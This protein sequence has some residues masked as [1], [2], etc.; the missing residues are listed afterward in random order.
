MKLTQKNYFSPKANLEYM[1]V[2]QFKS[3]EKC[4]ATALAEIHGT[5]EREK[6]TALL[7]GSYV[8]AY[9]EGQ[10][11][12]F[13]IENPQIFKRDAT[14]KA[15]YAQAD[16]I[17]QR[18]L[19]DKLFTEYMSGKKQ[20][21]M[22]GEI[23]GVPVKIKV[24]SL[25]TDKIVDLK[26][27]RDFEN[28]RDADKGI[29][30]WFE[31]WSYDLQGAVYQEIVRQNTGKTLPFY[32]AAATKEKVPDIDI[33]HLNQKA[34]DFAFARFKDNVEMYDAVKKGIIPP[35][36]CERCDYCKSTKVL[37][38]PTDSDEFYLL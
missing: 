15:E 18:I 7:V 11:P 20:V 30:P 37:T 36:R 3:F 29:L 33:V 28:I 21:I 32:L 23:C 34:L 1:S 38:E 24:D 19:K 13:I 25:H 17:I 27:M 16:A 14:L 9:F 6:T 10:L 22:T 4:Q 2:S 5:Y 26:I 35:E 12:R 8:D 31:G